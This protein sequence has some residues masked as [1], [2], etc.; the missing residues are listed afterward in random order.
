M[1]RLW[2]Y[3]AVVPLAVLLGC[4]VPRHASVEHA[5][6]TP[7]VQSAATSWK[8]V[9][10]THFPVDAPLGS[11]SGCK[12]STHICTGLP[13]ALRSQWWA[14]PD[15]WPDT[16]A[17]RH[18]AVSGYYSP[19]T[20]VWIAAGVMNIRMWRGTGSVHSAAL[21]PKA[22][23]GRIYGK[24]VET[25]RVPDPV[26]G[27]KSAHMLWAV[28]RPTDG[29]AYEI[30]FPE[31]GWGSDIR[32]FIH[33]ATHRPYFFTTTAFNSKWHTS[34]IEWTPKGLWLYLDGK[35]VGSLAGPVADVPLR[36]ILQ[37]ETQV[38]G[39]FPPVNSSSTMQIKYVAYYSWVG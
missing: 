5:A 32:A 18:L 15:G 29:S 24:Y 10:S 17:Q 20:T 7:A 30:D 8:L 25:F 36:W 35:L 39:T 38:N 3:V 22:A 4:A 19:S 21:L 27:Y 14:Y 13:A 11:F 34:I 2:R 26:R 37:N 31:A 6:T 16:A 33:F 1:R 9:Y 12:A 23:M 28:P